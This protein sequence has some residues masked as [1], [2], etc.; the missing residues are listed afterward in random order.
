V[1]GASAESWNSHNRNAMLDVDSTENKSC[2]AEM[3]TLLN[4]IE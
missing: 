2:A 1:V 4:W 3:D